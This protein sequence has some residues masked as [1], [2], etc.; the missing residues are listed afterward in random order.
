MDTCN[1]VHVTSLNGRTKSC[2]MALECAHLELVS[3][4]VEEGWSEREVAES[5][6]W[7]ALLHVELLRGG[8]SELEDVQRKVAILLA[9][10]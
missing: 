9:S 8:G 1:L 3:K 4:A 2:A 7:R 6:L 5:F 10:N